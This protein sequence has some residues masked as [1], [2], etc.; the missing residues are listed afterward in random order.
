VPCPEHGQDARATH[1]SA[2]GTRR[3]PA[4]APVKAFDLE[5]GSPSQADVTG[6]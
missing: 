2:E 4:S 1:R 6:L 5:G 3:V